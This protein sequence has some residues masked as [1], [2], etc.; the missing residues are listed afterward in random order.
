MIELLVRSISVPLKARTT[1][2]SVLFLYHPVF[3]APRNVYAGA[4]IEPLVTYTL[5]ATSDDTSDNPA[6]C[7]SNC[8]TP[9]MLPIR[10]EP[11]NHH[12]VFVDDVN[13]YAG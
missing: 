3:T 5:G 12:P 1:L 2:P 9:P 13:A 8:C 6:P 10:L 11:F 4:L 7:R